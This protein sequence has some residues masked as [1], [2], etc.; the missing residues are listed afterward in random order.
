MPHR[1]LTGEGRVEA[2]NLY[3]DAEYFDL[4]PPWPRP[5]LL[6]ASR[7]G[8][9]HPR[10]LCRELARS[11]PESGPSSRDSAPGRRL[12]PA[13]ALLDGRVAGIAA[14]LGYSREGFSRAFN[15]A[16]GI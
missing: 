1:C 6:P 12:P 14:K 5:V 2:V 10:D 9:R 13:M 4:S 15:R 8:G 16:N 3:M 11:A 7:F